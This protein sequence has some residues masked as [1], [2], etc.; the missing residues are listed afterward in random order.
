LTKNLV[1]DTT[2]EHDINAQ[3][4]FGPGA[5]HDMT[6]HINHLRRILSAAIS[7]RHAG[8]KSLAVFDLDSTLFD[9]A[10]RLEKILKDFA[11]DPQ[12]Q[13]MYPQPISV[14]SK[15]QILKKDWGLQDSLARAGLDGKHPEFEKALRQFWRKH[16]FSN[17]YLH[18]DQP[19]Q[20]AVAYV[21]ALHDAGTEI[22]YLT[23]RDVARM[24]KGSQETLI[25]WDF[26]LDQKAQLVLKPQKELD[27]AEFKTNWFASLPENSLPTSIS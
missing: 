11:L 7:A 9:V 22:V 6:Q 24:Q 2:L 12:H 5:V 10:P 21:R 1:N 27:D 14:F 15:L 20:G 4:F 18:F 16:F 17:E 3:L 13:K 8:L 26:P 19:Y 25:K 23:G